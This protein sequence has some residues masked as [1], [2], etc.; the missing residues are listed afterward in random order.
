MPESLF[1]RFSKWIRTRLGLLRVFRIYFYV[2]R[3]SGYIIPPRD[4]RKKKRYDPKTPIQWELSFE[5]RPFFRT[6]LSNK[7]EAYA[8]FED[9]LRALVREQE[10]RSIIEFAFKGAKTD[11]DDAVFIDAEEMPQTI[12]NRYL[13]MATEKQEEKYR[14]EGK[15]Q[16]AGEPDFVIEAMDFEPVDYIDVPEDRIKEFQAE[17]MYILKLFRPEEVD[18]EPYDSWKGEWTHEL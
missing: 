9:G 7:E 18:E 6:L 4:V 5:E 12:L 17:D 15:V 8:K 14:K 11:S 16:V 13:M 2:V 10:K 1:T 3:V